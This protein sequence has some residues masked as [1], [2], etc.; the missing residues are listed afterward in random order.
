MTRLEPRFKSLRQEREERLET[1]SIRDFCHGVRGGLCI[2]VQLG[3]E[4][5]FLLSPLEPQARHP[6]HPLCV[7]V[8][9][10]LPWFFIS[11]CHLCVDELLSLLDRA[12]LTAGQG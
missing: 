1:R 2:P 7:P 5:L 11:T 6:T 9:A 4:P 3:V 10:T 8:L 12:L